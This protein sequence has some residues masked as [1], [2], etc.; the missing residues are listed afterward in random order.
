MMKLQTY[1]DANG[2]T[3]PTPESI[4]QCTDSNAVILFLY[5]IN[6]IDKLVTKMI[7]KDLVNTWLC[8][9]DIISEILLQF[10]LK[11][12]Y[13][14]ELLKVHPNKMFA[15]IKSITLNQLLLSNSK[16]N[17]K[18]RQWRQKEIPYGTTHDL[19]TSYNILN[20]N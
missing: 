3:L 20:I 12:D 17:Y 14:L 8:K 15:Y 19:E 1:K 16:I 11:K 10:V 2:Y 6:Y 7:N 5:D 13:L 4:E 18:P 9:E